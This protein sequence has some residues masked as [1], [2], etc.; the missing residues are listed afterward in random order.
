MIWISYSLLQCT[1]PAFF[2]PSYISD[3]SLIG[4]DCDYNTFVSVKGYYKYNGC[5]LM[6]RKYVNE[7]KQSVL[8][9]I[10]QSDDRNVIMHKPGIH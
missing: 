4:I 8:D 3:H 10:E 7:T 1:G 6:N 2:K 5:L 9:I